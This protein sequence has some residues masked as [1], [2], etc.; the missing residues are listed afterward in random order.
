MEGLAK[1]APVTINGLNV[2]KVTNIDF[3]N[4]AGGLV[5]EFTVENDFDFSKK[6]LVRIYSSGLIGGKSL[7]IFPDY[8]EGMLA[9]SGDTL[10]GEIEKGML[11]A[12]TARLGP[13]ENKVNTTLATIDTLMQGI[14]KVI[15]DDT[16]MDLQKTI[17]NLSRLTETLNSV[18]KKTD[19]LLGENNQK[20]NRTFTNLDITTAN[21]ARLSDSLSKIETGK[22][23]TNIESVTAQLND[24]V[25]R[26]DG[27]E[28]TLGKML[29][30]DQI[31]LNLEGASQQLEELIQ[32]LKL[33]P[34]RYVHFSLFGKR[35]K[36]YA[37]P[38]DPQN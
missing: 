20:L 10:V 18:T 16:R 32:D 35:D 1:S 14:I 29:N 22:M 23:V 12:V 36:G 3:A 31:Y 4:Q 11:D 38:E 33:N 9:Q 17:Y 5:V 34:K 26:L 8:S 7:G 24:I 13:L 15:D 25:S 28:G 6:S 30:D 19:A 27:G 37:P 21:F 2:G